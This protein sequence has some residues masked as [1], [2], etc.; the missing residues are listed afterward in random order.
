MTNFVDR[1]ARERLAIEI[2]VELR[3]RG[4]RL[5]ETT[6]NISGGGLLMTCSNVGVKAGMYVTVHLS[7]PLVHD[8]TSR[9]L[10]RRARVVRCEPGKIAIQWTSLKSMIND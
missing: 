2:P 5:N 1:R 8:K 7:W 6:V 9:T 10:T 4:V 3:Y